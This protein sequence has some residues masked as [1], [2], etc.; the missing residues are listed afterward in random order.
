MYRSKIELHNVDCLPFMKQCEDKQFDLA[1]VDPPY[2]IGMDGKNNWSGSKHEVKDWDN[3]APST[4][5]FNE[6]IRISKNQIVW[7]ANH[8]I[9]RMPFDSKCWL[10]WDKKNDGFSFADGEMAWTSFDTAV[11][12]FRYHRGQQ[13]DKR[14]HPT[15]KPKELYRWILKNYA[16]EGQ[17]IFDS[18]LGSGSIAVACDDMGFD[19]VAT[20]IDK[21][22]FEKANKRLK[23]YRNQQALF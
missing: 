6:L 23:P 7:G 1:I 22:Y 13:T 15:Q 18:H 11:R 8:F 4:E 14:I 19:L 16:E 2:G 17:T 3:H 12:F 20:E 21:D 9:S 5:Y 10:I